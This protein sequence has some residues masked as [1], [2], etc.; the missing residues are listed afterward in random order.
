MRHIVEMVATMTTWA[1]IMLA[2]QL[3]V[4]LNSIKDGERQV[5]KSLF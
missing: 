1:R 4:L 2:Q 5:S 3:E